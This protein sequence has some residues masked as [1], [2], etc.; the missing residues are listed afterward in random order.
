MVALLVCGLVALALYGAQR[1]ISGDAPG[2]STSSGSGRQSSGGAVEGRAGPPVVKAEEA[3][4]VLPAQGTMPDGWGLP[5]PGRV[6][7]G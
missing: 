5:R 4:Q 2:Q 1:L 6:L 3:D 7:A